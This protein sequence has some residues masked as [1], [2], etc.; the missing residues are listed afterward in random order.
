MINTI[1]DRLEGRNFKNL[2]LQSGLEL[3]RL[4][5][6]IGPN[7]SGKSNLIG[8]LQFLQQC[9]ADSNGEA[10]RGRTSFE[11]AIFQ[12]GG[13]RILDATL[14]MPANVGIN[15]Q[16]TA[17]PKSTTLNLELLVQSAHRQVIIDSEDLGRDQG[18]SDPFY[19][20]RAHNERSGGSGKGV[21]SIFSDEHRTTTRFEPI[22]DI[23]VNELALAV[24]PRLLETSPFSPEQTPLYE[25]RREI[26]NSILQ[27]R[28]YNANN[29]DLRQI[30]FAEPKLGKSDNFLSPS[31]DNLALVLHNLVQADF[32]FEE[33][34]NQAMTEIF[35]STRRIRAVTSGRLSLTVEWFVEGC[36]DP[37][38]LNE[39][40][41][42][43]VRMLCWAIILHSPK[44]PSMIVIDEPEIGIHVAWFPILA[45][46]IKQAAH[47]TQII[48]STHSPDL[49]DHFTDQLATD[50][51]LF[52]FQSDPTSKNHYII[53]QLQKRAIEAWLMDGWQLGDLYRVGN[54]EV[55]GWPW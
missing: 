32:E 26:I 16:F 37:F 20:Y 44:L 11:D 42:G 41:D 35:P 39:M 13:S 23:P 28:F 3:S 27:W 53:K 30:R 47:R 45:E 33:D 48:I 51:K 17:G 2:R 7:G 46:W 54:P 4:N 43:T 49:L 40:S 12:L 25:P 14:S 6:L 1:L 52:S 8:L 18:Q 31:G 15:Y 34:I 24:T 55:G 19:Y 38:F 22:D 5:V 21:F 50:N 9:L 29:M 10:D 36:D